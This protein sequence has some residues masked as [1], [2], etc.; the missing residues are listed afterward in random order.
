[1]PAEPAKKSISVGE[2]ANHLGTDPRALRVFLRSA[3][4]VVG[5][6]TR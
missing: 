5:R 4:R 1:M 3:D 6:G 2:L